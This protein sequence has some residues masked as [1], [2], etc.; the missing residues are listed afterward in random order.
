MRKKI[1]VFFLLA[2]F[3]SSTADAQHT[4]SW[5]NKEYEVTKTS[6]IK[7]SAGKIY[8]YTE[9][10]VALTSGEYELKPINPNSSSDGFLL[11]RLSKEEQLKRLRESPKPPESNDFITGKKFL[12]FAAVDISGNHV[13]TDDL[14][15]K[16]LVINFW[17]INCYPCRLERP[18]LNQLVNEYKSDTGV[19]FIAVSLDPKEKLE[20]FLKQNPFDYTII[21]DGNKIVK[22]YPITSYPAHVIVSK[23]GKIAFHTVSYN[24]VTG[25]WMRKMIDELKKSD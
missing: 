6:I 5:N 8:D 24:A 12:S 14:K 13:N 18:Y 22:K 23:D 19:V 9:C 20:E 16:I 4:F 25:Y 3:L 21:P 17:Y 1:F 2:V 10:M 7:D 11:L 15:G